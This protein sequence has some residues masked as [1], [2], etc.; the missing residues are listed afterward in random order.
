M[1]SVLG[2]GVVVMLVCLAVSFIFAISTLNLFFLAFFSRIFFRAF[3][4][5]FRLVLRFI[6]FRYAAPLYT[7]PQT[8]GYTPMT[9]GSVRDQRRIYLV[10]G[11]LRDGGGG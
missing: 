2:L 8:A 7:L 11:V 4:P 9:H 3:P 1:F 5:A 10:G 6:S